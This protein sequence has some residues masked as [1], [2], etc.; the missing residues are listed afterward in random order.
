MLN[1]DII[2]WWTDMST[3]NQLY[4]II[5]IPATLIFIY[6]IIFS[7]IKKEIFSQSKEADFSN[8][9]KHRVIIWENILAFFTLFSWVGLACFD[10]G[11]SFNL[12][13]SL[14]IVGGILMSVLMIS[15]NQLMDNIG[16]N[17]D[18]SN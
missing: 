16:K 3:A 1:L 14:S 4:W 5:C 10:A 9:I 18:K 13:F 17:N 12:T 8:K 6:Q 15:I 2:T 7:F 11:Y